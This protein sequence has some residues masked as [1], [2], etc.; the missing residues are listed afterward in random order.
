MN[1][2]SFVISLTIA[3]MM[4]DLHPTQPYNEPGVWGKNQ[5]C[6][7]WQLLFDPAGISIAF[8]LFS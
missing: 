5:D 7:K 1:H 3:V 2:K 8:S 4:I 6:L